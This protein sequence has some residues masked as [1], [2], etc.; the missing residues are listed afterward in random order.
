MAV[1]GLSFG[2]SWALFRHG[3]WLTDAAPA[4]CVSKKMCGRELEPGL[5]NKYVAL[6]RL[7]P[8]DR[9]KDSKEIFPRASDV[10]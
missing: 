4:A 8:K 5:M 6:G 7:A 2:N 1:F 3:G 9:K 10:M